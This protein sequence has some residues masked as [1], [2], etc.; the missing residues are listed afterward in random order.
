MK[1]DLKACI[2]DVILRL[3]DR[4]TSEQILSPSTN[5][6]KI[7][8]INKLVKA[9]Q[10]K[11]ALLLMTIKVNKSDASLQPVSSWLP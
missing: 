10:T 7:V 6:I 8:K 1:A 9:A 5:V 11:Q 2:K 3:F 4:F